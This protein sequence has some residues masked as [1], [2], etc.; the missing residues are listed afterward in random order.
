M[1]DPRAF[2]ERCRCVRWRAALAAASPSPTSVRRCPLSKRRQRPDL[3]QAAG[4]AHIDIKRLRINSRQPARACAS[5]Q[6]LHPTVRRPAP[7]RRLPRFV[8]CLPYSEPLDNPPVPLGSIFPTNEQQHLQPSP[9]P[10]LNPPPPQQQYSQQHYPIPHPGLAR[11]WTTSTPL[12]H[13][14]PS[15]S[16][17]APPQMLRAPEVPQLRT[18]A[19][20]FLEP[21]S[22][23]AYA[24]MNAM[25]ARLHMERVAAGARAAWDDEDL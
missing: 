23:A 16:V 18:P 19:A 7:P 3:N 14:H 25:L 5:P 1:Q 15:C 4:D 10:H 9:Q 11:A 12:S 22:A 2:A 8:L 13:P 6:V 20:G 21:R 24:E 17:D